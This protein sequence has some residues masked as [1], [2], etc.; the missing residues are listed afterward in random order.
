M[1]IAELSIPS[2]DPGLPA[3]EPAWNIARLFPVQGRWPVEEYLRLT[4]STT[5]LVEFRHGQISVFDM[6]T[7]QHQR[8]VRFLLIAIFELLTR[9]GR[10]EVISAPLRL[11]ISDGE[12][13]EPDLLVRTRDIPGPDEQRYW[14]RADLVVE[15]VSEG[16]E[17]RDRDFIE[18]R[19][20]YASAGIP[21]Y[22]IVDPARAE[23]TVLS[24]NTQQQYGEGTVYRQGQMLI[25]AA[26][27]DLSLDVSAVFA[28]AK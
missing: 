8:I 20:S 7:T 26:V 9:R 5:W 18:K 28:A 22:W 11:K 21:E 25:S 3:G 2:K 6:P 17:T 23:I 27:P 12:Y 15:V 24:L 4:D 16:P 14:T 1:S 10:G 13:R 19:Q